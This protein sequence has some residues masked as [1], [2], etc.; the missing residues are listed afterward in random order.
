[1]SKKKDR[2]NT[3]YRCC[4]ICCSKNIFVTQKRHIFKK[5]KT[6]INCCMCRKEVEVRHE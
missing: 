3:N 6:Y 1:M 2:L 5:T 4:P